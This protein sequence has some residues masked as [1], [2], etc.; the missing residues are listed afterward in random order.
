MFCGIDGAGCFFLYRLL[1]LRAGF[2]TV[3]VV[4]LMLLFLRFMLLLSS[5]LCLDASDSNEFLVESK[6]SGTIVYS[7]LH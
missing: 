3:V 6:C 4:L 7:M 2:F 1:F 5:S